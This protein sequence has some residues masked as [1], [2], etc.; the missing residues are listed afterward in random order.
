MVTCPH[1]QIY[2]LLANSISK[3]VHEIEVWYYIKKIDT[4]NR[5][6]STVLLLT[7][8]QENEGVDTFILLQ[9]SQRLIHLFVHH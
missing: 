7:A 6:F 5:D 3:G 1:P 9:G 4:K 8:L 2:C